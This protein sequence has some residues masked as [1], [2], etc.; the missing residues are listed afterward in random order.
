M[1]TKRAKGQTWLT[2]EQQIEVY[3]EKLKDNFR[4]DA[5]SFII[6]FDKQY[7]GKRLKFPCTNDRGEGT[8]SPAVAYRVAPAKVKKLL[9]KPEDVKTIV[10]PLL[11]DMFEKFKT[12]KAREIETEEIKKSTMLVINRSFKKLDPYFGDKLVDELERDDWDEEWRNFCEWFK[13]TYPG[14]TGRG[15]DIANVVKYMSALVRILHNN[16]TIKKRPRIWDPD[17]KKKEKTAKKTKIRVFTRGQY[18]MMRRA[19]PRLERLVI[20]L[21]GDLAFRISSD[22]LALKEDQ[23]VL[24]DDDPRIKIEGD[25]KASYFVEIPVSKPLARS[26]NAYLRDFP[27]PA[28]EHVFWQTTKPEQAIKSQQVKTTKYIKKA[29][30]WG[31]HHRLRDYRLSLDFGNPNIPAADTM[32]FRRVSYQVALKHYIKPSAAARARMREHSK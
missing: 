25:D 4:G 21:G 31:T 15:E 23:L 6:Y 5:R 16:G 28:G 13:K 11:R 27:N 12:E 9:L 2:T 8:K 29:A 3:G 19:A 30:G 32:I 7:D 24:D 20:R 10:R 18:V 14:V 17:K 1:N 22:C 26:L